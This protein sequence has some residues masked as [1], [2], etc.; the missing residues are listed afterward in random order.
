MDTASVQAAYSRWSKFYDGTFGVLMRG[1]RRRA[2]AILDLQAGES[3]LE[4]GVGTGLSLSLM[5]DGCRLTGVD[6][7]RPMLERALPR[8]RHG[9]L[10]CRAALVEADGARL[11]FAD[12]TFDAAIAPF[13]VSAT[14]NPSALMRDM[15]RVCRPGGRL[16]VLNH[17]T[18][19]SQF[20]ARIEQG[21]SPVTSSVLG[22]HA[23]FP[24]EPLFESASITIDS[25]QRVTPVGS[26]YA[27]TFLRRDECCEST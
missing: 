3:A 20:L 13:V 22:F 25:V 18:S 16:L 14:P 2:Y 8:V 17:F 6:F 12:G 9:K 10:R 21:L 15:V 19:R 24:L 27:V 7:S 11:P 5:P 1:A 23:D 26:W 4:V